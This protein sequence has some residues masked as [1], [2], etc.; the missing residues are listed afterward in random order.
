[1]ASPKIN[2]KPRIG[3]EFYA[4]NRNKTETERQATSSTSFS[5]PTNVNS[6]NLQHSI[7]K[8]SFG[9]LIHPTIL[10]SLVTNASGHTIRIADLATGTAIWPIEVATFFARNHPDIKVKIYGFDISLAQFPVA[11]NIPQNVIL[12]QHDVTEQ[13]KEGDHEKY[14]FIHV[15]ALATVL[16]DDQWKEVLGNLEQ[17]LSKFCESR[18]Y[19]T[20]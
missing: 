19:E 13:F 11:K 7:L 6:L 14:D 15:R 18:I 4:L 9:F 20:C 17:C 5:I 12:K 10:S 16:G 1:M 2:S 8:K 3:D